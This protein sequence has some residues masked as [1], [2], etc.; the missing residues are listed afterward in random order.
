[1]ANTAREILRRSNW[2]ASKRSG[3]S[4]EGQREGCAQVVAT[5]APAR[6]PTKTRKKTTTTI[7]TVLDRLVLKGS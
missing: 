7:I 6:L 4:E 2:P 1:M 5:I 3:C